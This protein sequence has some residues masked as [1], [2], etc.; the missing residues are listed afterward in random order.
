LAAAPRLADLANL[1]RIR[2]D[3][4]IYLISGSEDPV[5]LQLGGVRI[6][7]ERYRRA[8]ILDISHDFYLGGR[9]EMLNEINRDVVRACLVDWICARLAK[10]TT[11]ATSAM[12]PRCTSDRREHA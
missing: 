9:H 3:L 10:G 11:S 1:D 8:G 4:P 7:L 6:L 2:K 5:G 12:P